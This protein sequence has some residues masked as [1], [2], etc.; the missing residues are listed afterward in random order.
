MLLIKELTGA[1]IGTTKHWREREN[2]DRSCRP[3]SSVAKMT[4]DGI[5]LAIEMHS[6][7][8]RGD[9]CLDIA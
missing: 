7:K 5:N 1:S 2:K 3:S 9:F 6:Q 4:A 8:G